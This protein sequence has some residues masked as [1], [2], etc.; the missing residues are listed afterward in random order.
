MRVKCSAVL[1]AVAVAVPLLAAAES[2]PLRPGLWEMKMQRDGVDQSARMRDMEE[3]L[4]NMPPEQRQMVENMMKQ[5]GVSIEGGGNLK[6]CMTKETLDVD[7]WHQQQQGDTGCKTQ[8][9]RSGKVWRWHQS[10]PA[11]N[12]S[13]S[14]GE[15]IFVS[16][17]KYTMK[18]TTTLDEDGA[19][20]THTMTGTSTWL[21]ADCGDIKPAVPKKK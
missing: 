12:A 7:A 21:G 9:T 3:R 18:S 16:D 14:D 20:K 8:T 10:C 19:K 6:I 15:A 2:A 11:P 5:H 13:E 1:A 4:K 17:T